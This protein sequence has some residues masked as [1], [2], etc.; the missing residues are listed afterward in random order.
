MLTKTEILVEV[1]HLECAVEV[2]VDG[3]VQ[4]TGVAGVGHAGHLALDGLALLDAKGVV[5][6]QHSLAPVGWGD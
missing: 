1:A 6:V 5:Q 2:D 4:V 3:D